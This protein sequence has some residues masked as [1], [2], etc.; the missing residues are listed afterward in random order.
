[1]LFIKC[2]DS[3]DFKIVAPTWA[4]G[5]PYIVIGN[6]FHFVSQKTFQF[7]NDIR[8]FYLSIDI[9][10]TLVYCDK[11]HLC[12]VYFTGQKCLEF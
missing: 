1:M 11:T 6:S 5:L 8:S 3:L 7:K 12:K 10:K 2:L 4:L 9:Q